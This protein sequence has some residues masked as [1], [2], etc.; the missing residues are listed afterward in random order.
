[1]A[2]G[3]TQDGPRRRPEAGE[4]L[5]AAN[6]LPT[7]WM[8]ELRVRQWRTLINYRHTL[9]SRRTAIRNTIRSV[10]N[11]QGERPPTGAKAWTEAGLAILNKMARPIE[12]CSVHELWRGQLHTELPLLAELAQQLHAV[13]DKLDAVAKTDTRTTRPRT[14]PGVGPRLSEAVVAWIDDPQRAGG[15]FVCGAGTP[16][17]SVGDV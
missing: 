3:E 13:E 11:T 12:G 2:A 8:P 15:G 16:A 10:L 4:R 7:V 14:I 17:A 1:M 6:Q 5:S 9:V